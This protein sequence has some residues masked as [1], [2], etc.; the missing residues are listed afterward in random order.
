NRTCEQNDG[1]ARVAFCPL[2]QDRIQA[3]RERQTDPNSAPHTPQSRRK[4]DPE[5]VAALGAQGHANAELVGPL[6]HCVGGHAVKPDRRQRQCQTAKYSEDPRRQVLL[7]PLLPIGDPGVEILGYAVTLLLR[8]HRRQVHP[9]RVQQGERRRLG[10]HL[11][12]SSCPQDVKPPGFTMGGV[13]YFAVNLVH[14]REFISRRTSCS[15]AYSG[16]LARCSPALKSRPHAW[17]SSAVSVI[18]SALAVSATLFCTA[19]AGA[20]GACHVPM[21]RGESSMCP[22]SVRSL[23]SA[24]PAKLSKW[25]PRNFSAAA[26]S[27]RPLFPSINASQRTCRAFALRPLSFGS[28]SVSSAISFGSLG[29]LEP[30]KNPS[31]VR[32]SATFLSPSSRLATSLVLR[33][34]ISQLLAYPPLLPSFMMRAKSSIEAEYCMALR[35]RTNSGIPAGSKPENWLMVVPVIMI[36]AKFPPKSPPLWMSPGKPSSGCVC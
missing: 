22:Q 16:C 36:P 19:P 10:P 25:S 6:R 35:A 3:Q 4:H 18:F 13:P 31:L 1:I 26:P 33:S 24:C 30:T 34:A 28:K 14:P 7:L 17:P 23:G 5:Y 27:I 11:P 8:V 21:P 15:Q 12:R 20:Y 29:K 9:H 2:P 32:C